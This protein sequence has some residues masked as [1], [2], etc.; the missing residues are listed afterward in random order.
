MSEPRW[1]WESGTRRYRDR[2]TGRFISERRALELRDR[3]VESRG[4]Q[5][6]GFVDGV[7]DGIDPTDRQAWGRAVSRV[8][9][10]GWRRIENTMI[11]EYVYGRGGINAMTSADRAVLQSMLTEQRRYWRNFMTEARS[12]DL[13][14][15]QISARAQ[16][17]HHTSTAFHERGRARA[18]GV[19]LPAEPGDG[20]T[21]C[22]SY[23]KCHWSFRAIEGGVE[24]YWTPTG[25]PCPGCEQ[26]S[27]AWSPFV[28]MYGD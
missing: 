13:S 18:W 26:N 3:Y 2:E 23:C 28:Y 10:L 11:T 19:V 21:P 15:K 1:V 16:M 27:N 6:R 14:A 8:N 20:G 12:G 5:M 7:L 4:A 25:N 17:Y 22:L 24:C 9:R